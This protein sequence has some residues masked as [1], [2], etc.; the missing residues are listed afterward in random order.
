MNFVMESNRNEMNRDKKES[1]ERNV[2]VEANI[3]I[4]RSLIK[5]SFMKSNK[6]NRYIDSFRT[7][8]GLF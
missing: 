2:F 1:C 5:T 6:S 3:F 4:S 7:F 8:L